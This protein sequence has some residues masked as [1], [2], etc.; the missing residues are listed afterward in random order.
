MLRR[1]IAQTTNS[2]VDCNRHSNHA[3]EGIRQYHE[4]LEVRHSWSVVLAQKLQP[5]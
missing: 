4:T 1:A 2:Y 5:N 3:N